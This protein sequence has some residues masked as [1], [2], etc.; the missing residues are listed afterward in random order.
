MIIVKKKKQY[1]EFCQIHNR[2]K[3]CFPKNLLKLSKMYMK[4]SGH[5][6][7]SMH[8]Y[9][10]RNIRLSYKLYKDKFVFCMFPLHAIKH[11]N[12]GE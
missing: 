12:N 6:A 10:I 4:W 5:G 8:P 2:K 3:D 7:A 9:S 11:K 1:A